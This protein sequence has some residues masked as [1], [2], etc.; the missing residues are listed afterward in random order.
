MEQNQSV[1]GKII[2]EVLC[3]ENDVIFNKIAY[4]GKMPYPRERGL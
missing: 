3:M 2:E 4:Y 1:L